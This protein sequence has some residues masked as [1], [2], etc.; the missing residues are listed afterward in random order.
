M[1]TMPPEDALKRL[2]EFVD[3]YREDEPKPLAQMVAIDAMTV[4]NA[5]LNRTA[6]DF[7]AMEKQVTRLVQILQAYQGQLAISNLL[8]NGVTAEED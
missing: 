1:L 6:P 3:Q 4:L 8:V 5:A 2:D 7:K